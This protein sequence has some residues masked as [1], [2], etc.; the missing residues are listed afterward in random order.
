MIA[1]DEPLRS[2]HTTTL[3]EL[4]DQ[5]GLSRPGHHLPGGQADR[6]A[7][8]R[9]TWPTP[10]SAT[11]TRRWGWPSTGGRLAV[12]TR[13]QVWEFH[14]QPAVAAQARPARPA[15]RLLPAAAGP[16]HRRHRRPRDGLGRATSCGSS[17]PGSRAC[18]RS[19]ADYSFVP[20]W[21]PP[22]VTALAPEDRCHLNG[23]ALVRRPS[24][25]TSPPWATTDTA[26]G[27]RANKATR[28]ACCSTCRRGEVVAPRAVDAALAAVARRPAVGAGVRGREPGRRGPGDRP[29][30][31]RWPC[32][33]GSPAGWTSSAR[34]RS[35]GCRRCARRPCSAASR[36]PSGCRSRSARCGVW[37]VDMRTGQT[38]AFLRFEAGVQEVFAVQVLPGRALPGAA[39][40][41]RG[42]RRWPTRSCCPTR[43]WP[44]C[45]DENLGD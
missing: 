14:N 20:R 30:A 33:P 9:R 4:L 7:G 17:T 21:R 32:C 8:R 5:R 43:P 2:V 26:G 1:P 19:T 40:R 42:R 12:G 3:P 27:W 22:F 35:S 13:T 31:R 15:R 28:R 18:V 45:L 37:V 38:V 36:S 24:R 41:G 11:S 6:R 23:L 10:T 16:R 29:A 34:S 44:T 25:G 39:Q